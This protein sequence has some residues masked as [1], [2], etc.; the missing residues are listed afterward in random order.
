[1]E[2][3]I[4][5]GMVQRPRMGVSIQ[6]VTAEDAEVYGL[7]SVS[8]V[9][10]Q[11]V[12]ENTPAA[13]V[14]EPE[15]VIVAI[16]GEPIGYVAELQAKVAEHRPG[17]RV[18]VTVFRD[19]RRIDVDVRLAEAPINGPRAVAE[20]PTVH[21]EDRLGIN[22]QALDAQLAQQ[23]GFNAPGGV[24]LREVAPGSAAQRRNVGAFRGQKLVRVNDDVIQT[25]EDVRDALDGA[26]PGEIVSLHFQDA[27][28]TQ[29]VV[30]LRMP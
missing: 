24:V 5:F 16:G 26:A 4:E 20:A 30:N 7:P 17:D 27:E 15:D 1:M 25:P 29:R 14:L 19:R 2:D 23:L 9:L 22:V 21:S 8:G 3:L 12:Q 10:V 18:S 11:E 13:G 28:G 6:N